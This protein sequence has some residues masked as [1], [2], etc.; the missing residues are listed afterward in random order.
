MNTGPFA[1]TMTPDYCDELFRAARAKERVT[2]AGWIRSHYTFRPGTTP[3]PDAALCVS[4]ALGIAALIER[5]GGAN[6]AQ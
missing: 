5:Q 6:S 1:R 2:L 3:A 4:A